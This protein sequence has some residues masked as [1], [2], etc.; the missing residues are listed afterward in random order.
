MRAQ[1]C[2][3][4]TTVCDVTGMLEWA[5]S[6]KALALVQLHTIILMSYGK[7][8]FPRGSV[9]LNGNVGILMRRFLLVYGYVV[10]DVDTRYG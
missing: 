9:S 6:V 1:A 3:S 7:H 8:Y 4:T 5:H 10:C 2:H